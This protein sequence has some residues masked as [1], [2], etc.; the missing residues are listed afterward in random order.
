MNNMNNMN[1]VEPRC[2]QSV[3][4]AVTPFEATNNTKLSTTN[5]RIRRPIDAI[6]ISSAAI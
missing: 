1:N 4:F 6:G 2:V 3:S 5:A